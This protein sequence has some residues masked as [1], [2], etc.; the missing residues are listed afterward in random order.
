MIEGCQGEREV[1]L[2]D[3]EF[4][5]SAIIALFLGVI[6]EVELR[7][8]TLDDANIPYFSGLQSLL[9]FCDKYECQRAQKTIAV[10]LRNDSEPVLT[11][12]E[13]FV[14]GAM[15]DDPSICFDA[16][17]GASKVEKSDL[18]PGRIASTCS[19]SSPPPTFGRSLAPGESV[20]PRCSTITSAKV[21][22]VA[23]LRRWRR[24]P[25]AAPP[26]PVPPRP[27]ALVLEQGSPVHIHV[28]CYS[29]TT[30]VA[31]KE[32]V[33]G[34]APSSNPAAGSLQYGVDLASRTSTPVDTSIV[35]LF[36]M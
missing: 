30:N 19:S 23:I 21:C 15:H 13:L 27:S 8:D 24:E 26:R 22:A 3:P 1:T 4:E 17:Y 33:R 29:L 9:R 20:T 14:I 18:H 10:L 25:Q 34:K 12:L 7:L 36:S 6:T 31:L 2:V 11:P 16:L 35:R 5:H 32:L 28:N